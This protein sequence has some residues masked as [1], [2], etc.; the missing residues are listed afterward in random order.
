MANATDLLN[1][2]NSTKKKSKPKTRYPFGE[3]LNS[4]KNDHAEKQTLN[5]EKIFKENVSNQTS[6]VPNKENHTEKSVLVEKHTIQNHTEEKN[7]NLNHSTSK[8]TSIDHASDKQAIQEASKKETVLV[9]EKME[10]YFYK[11]LSKNTDYSQGEK[12]V[13]EYFFEKTNGGNIQEIPVSHTKGSKESG[14]SFQGYRAIVKKLLNTDI[15][16]VEY[17]ENESRK[18]KQG[19]VKSMVYKF[20]MP[21]INQ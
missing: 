2:I 10:L 1:K 4:L 16:S 8:N 5:S 17:K 7:T 6:T 11:W 13:I 9:D 15:L 21:E 20:N 14:L 12:K 3:S 18:G 19:G